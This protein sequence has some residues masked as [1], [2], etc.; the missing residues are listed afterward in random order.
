[1]SNWCNQSSVVIIV[2]AVI[3]VSII[4][5]I[6]RSSLTVPACNLICLSFD[7]LATFIHS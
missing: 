2:V 7:A 3:I 1:M 6:T 4:I 5:N